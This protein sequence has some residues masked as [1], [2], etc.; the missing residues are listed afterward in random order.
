MSRGVQLL[1][2]VE[3]FRAEV[4]ESTQLSVGTDSLP[5]VKQLLRRTQEMLYADPQND[6]SFL[7][8]FPKITISAG[9]YYYDAPADLNVDRIEKV[10]VIYNGE[11]IPVERGIGFEQYADFDPENDERSS[12]IERWDLRWT[13]TKT[14]IEVWP[15]PSEN[16]MKLMF[17]CLRP[18]R[19]LVADTD[20]CDLD[21]ILIYLFAAGEELSA[22]KS[23]DA[24]LKLQLAQRH[25]NALRAAAQAASPTIQ[26]GLGSS[27]N[28][29]GRAVVR[30]PS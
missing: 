17:Q 5:H 6:W 26:M 20:V 24:E 21:D 25:L 18:L 10:C 9:A 19:P 30:V 1:Q 3:R 28:N 14:Q 13:G 2:L 16:G 7:R 11:P 23:K 15:K 12:P 27:G 8:M 29:I 4:R 22:K